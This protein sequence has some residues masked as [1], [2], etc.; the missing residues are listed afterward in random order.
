MTKSDAGTKD[1][2]NN[3][4]P[5]IVYPLL[6]IQIAAAAWL[7]RQWEPSPELWASVLV[8]SISIIFPAAWMFDKPSAFR[9]PWAVGLLLQLFGVMIMAM[10][11]VLDGLGLLAQKPT[12]GV[13]F[14]ACLLGLLWMGVYLSLFGTSRLINL[15]RQDRANVPHSKH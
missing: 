1:H 4:R 12:M 13:S 8:V 11:G 7:G 14:F 3:G 15:A 6:L 9:V 5:W 10:T 2:N